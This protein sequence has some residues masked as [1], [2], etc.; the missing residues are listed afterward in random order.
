MHNFGQN[1]ETSVMSALKHY[2]EYQVARMFG[3][4][5]ASVR[6]IRQNYL[7][8][9][10]NR[11]PTGRRQDDL[12]ANDLHALKRSEPVS[13]PSPK[14]EIPKVEYAGLGASIL[15]GF[16]TPDGQPTPAF[17][18]YVNQ[19]RKQ[20]GHALLDILHDH[21]IFAPEQLKCALDIYQ[22]VDNMDSVQ[23]AALLRVVS[24][25]VYETN[26]KD[27]TSTGT[28]VPYCK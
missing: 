27:P 2:S 12:F 23:L 13:T 3:L 8:N 4:R 15:S 25:K 9:Q 11:S 19:W 5:V 7:S 6:L 22:Q 28:H 17:W 20:S 16:F 26:V 24:Q 18:G 14:Y 21:E 1:T 10:I